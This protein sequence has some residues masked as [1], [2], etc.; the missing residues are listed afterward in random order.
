MRDRTPNEIGEDAERR[1]AKIL[2]GRMVKQSGGGKFLKLD[3]S[4]RGR[5]VYSVKATTRGALRI[6]S[7]LWREAVRG[8]RG[9]DGHGNG[10]KPAIV[11]EVDGELLVTC[12]LEDWAEL[13]TGELQPYI[14]PDKGLERRR[15]ASANPRDL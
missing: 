6:T 8:A 5:F 7:Q 2:G 4:D 9:A 11:T 14:Q 1:V 13:A 3:L 15:K 12:R 10:A